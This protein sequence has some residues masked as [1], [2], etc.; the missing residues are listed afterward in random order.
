MHVI[1]RFTFTASFYEM[2]ISNDANIL[3]RDFL[4]AEELN[5]GGSAMIP[6]ASGKVER[7]V[8]TVSTDDSFT[9]TT[10]FAIVAVDEV[11]NRGPVSNIIPITIGSTSQFEG[12]LEML[13]CTSL[14]FNLN[15][16]LLFMCCCFFILFHSCFVS[17]MTTNI[18]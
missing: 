11:G 18:L 14:Q 5:T 13:T 12:N 4:T 16:T 3:R 10:N 1:F 9:S 8:M 17:F 7:L 6:K 2:R 15:I